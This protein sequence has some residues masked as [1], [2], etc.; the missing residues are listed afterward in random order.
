MDRKR[1]LEI[2]RRVREVIGD[3]LELVIDT[4]GVRGLWDVPTAIQR[5]RS[6]EPY[7]LRWIE[8]PLLSHDLEGYARLRAARR[9]RRKLDARQ[10]GFTHIRYPAAD[11]FGAPLL[12][13]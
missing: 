6:L 9:G 12:S 11:A 2:V 13:I 7:R 1:D 8:Q 4:P 3:D 5:F 10:S